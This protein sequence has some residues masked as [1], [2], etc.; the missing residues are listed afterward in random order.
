MDQKTKK[1]SIII[2]NYNV[3]DYLAQCLMSVERAINGIDTEVFVVDNHSKDGSCTYICSMF[4]WV[5]LIESNHNLG[6]ARGNNVAIRRAV[7][8]YVLLLNPDTIVG[9]NVLR[10]ALAFMDEHPAAGGVGVRMYNANGTVAPESRRA[11]PSP[12]VAMRKFLGGGSRYYMSHLPWESP[13]QIEIVSGAFCMLRHVALNK[14]GLLDEDFFMYGEDIDLSYRLLK[15]G[16]ENWYLPLDI[17]HYKGESTNKSSF[18][19]VHVFY[20]AMLIF[21]RKHYSGLSWL[22]AIPI[23]F[24]IYM[25]ALLVMLRMV[26]RIIA[27]NLG[28]AVIKKSNTPY[29]I[30]IGGDGMLCR[31]E[32]LSLQKALDYCLCND[33]DNIKLRD[34]TTNVI[35]YDTMDFSYSTI[36][37]KLKKLS[38]SNV[39]LGTYSALTASIITPKEVFYLQ[40]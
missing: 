13:Q 30:Y 5:K 7:G 2:V 21:F 1:L 28:L 33:A 40:Q 19:Y 11:L 16:Y 31:C 14:V 10:D 35:V 25:Q 4:P 38:G 9:E 23:K 29:Y 24:A 20:N 26:P 39:R 12:M 34:N 3:K 15:A 17:I 36:I 18:R 27:H 22:I 8:E 32:S 37:S 6:F